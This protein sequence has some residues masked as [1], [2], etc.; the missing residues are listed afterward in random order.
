MEK[1]VAERFEY[2]DRLIREGLSGVGLRVD[3]SDLTPEET[4]DYVLA[5]EEEAIVE[6]AGGLD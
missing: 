4:V 3:S 6:A 5:H 2:L 1:H